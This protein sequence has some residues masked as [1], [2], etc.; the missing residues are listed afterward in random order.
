MYIGYV[1]KICLAVCCLSYVFS[2]NS[3]N[4]ELDMFMGRG[5]EYR[6]SYTVDDDVDYIE[7]S[8]FEGMKDLEVVRLSGALK[9]IG[10]RSFANTGI[11]KVRFKEGM[12]KIGNEAFA[13][14]TNLDS[15]NFPN[16]VKFLGNNVLHGSTVSEIFFPGRWKILKQRL[17]RND[18][19]YI[20]IDELSLYVDTG[21][22][23]NIPLGFI[24]C[25]TKLW[26]NGELLS[27]QGL[28]RIPEE[29]EE[30]SPLQELYGD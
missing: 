25:A 15:I 11:K 21:D 4:F 12:V 14:C 29:F 3:M 17:K 22:G 30:K 8:K 28:P 20:D 5:G 18:F 19:G 7:N 9:E 13:N 10:D 6:K 27:I 16:S 26:Q 24:P 2:S 1:S 23:K